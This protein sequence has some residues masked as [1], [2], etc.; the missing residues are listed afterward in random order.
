MQKLRNLLLAGLLMSAIVVSAQEKK[1]EEK[2]K[3]YQFTSVKEI[4]CTPVKDQYRSGTCWSFS[5]LGFLEAEMLRLG[6]PVVDLSEMFVVHHAYSDKAM[7]YVRLHGSLNFGAGGAFHDVTNVIKKYGIVPEEVYNGLNYGEEKHVHGELDRTLLDQVK[8]VVDNPNKKLTTA[9]HD[10]LNS[11]LDTYLGELPEKFKYQGKEYNPQS[12][13]QEVAGLNMDDYVEITSYTH[14][15]FYSRFIIEVPDNWSWDEVYNVPMSELEEII[16][17]AINTGFSVAWAADVS[18]KG[19][20]TSV[21]GVAVIPEVDKANM[22][23]AEISKWEKQTEKER[24]EDL[25][26]LSKPGAEKTITQEMRQM[27]FD[28]YQ[29]TDDHGML[30]VGTAKDQNGNMYYKVKNSW[31][32]YNDFDGFFYASKPYVKY[33]TMSVMIHKD[34]IPKNIR[35]KL[36]L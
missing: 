5:G 16:D 2:E 13:A 4:P 15:P 28:N 26:K 29:T 32:D 33:K 14:H 24:N 12:F 17:N 6:K 9:W 31:G 36:N 25:Y 1:E 11:T 30:I 27:D 8:G 19:F 34:A 23:D 10:A 18:E 21:K 7:K 20:A 35:K 22:S 3:G